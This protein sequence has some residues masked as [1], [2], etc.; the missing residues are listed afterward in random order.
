[1]RA[2]RGMA[3]RAA[4]LLILGLATACSTG[5]PAAEPGP[6]SSSAAQPP[7]PTRALVAWSTTACDA[8]RALDDLRR[9]ASRADLTGGSATTYVMGVANSVRGEA[10]KLQAVR[11]TGVKTADA[12]VAGV[13]KTLNDLYGRLPDPMRTVPGPEKEMEAKA[14]DAA[15]AVAA[16][17]PQGPGLTGVVKGEPRLLVAY[18]VTPAC[19]PLPTSVRPAGPAPTR[20]RVVWSETLCTY[21]E[22]PQKRP[23]RGSGEAGPPMG[24]QFHALELMSFIRDSADRLD[25]AADE[26]AAVPPTGV[27]EADR[28]RSR[29][30]SS[31]R[32]AAKKLPAYGNAELSRLSPGEL[33]AEADKVADTLKD[34]EPRGDELPALV[35]GLPEIAAAYDLAPACEAPGEGSPAP[36]PSG[37]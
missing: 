5:T 28:Y 20:A 27:A 23:P 35:K 30:L 15:K 8:V 13:T 31:I 21:A 12:Y 17:K 26:L 11:R 9:D 18:N 6:S 4:G 36:A 10:R 3:V 29:L 37:S 32:A 25:T 33:E 19:E 16:L 7:P 34:V 14:R 24:D 22:L 1:M 2:A